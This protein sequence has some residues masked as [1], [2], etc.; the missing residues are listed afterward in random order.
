M[1]RTHQG[2]KQPGDFWSRRPHSGKGYGKWPK[3]FCHR[4][5]RQQSRAL[6]REELK[7]L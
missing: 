5:E 2:G 7:Q 4:V 6:V 3:Y 1:A